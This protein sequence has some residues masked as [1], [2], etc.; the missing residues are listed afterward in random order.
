MGGVDVLLGAQWLAVA[1]LGTVKMFFQE[2][3]MQF[4]WSGKEYEL[5]HLW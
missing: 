2:F 3:F 1:P 5:G 4:F